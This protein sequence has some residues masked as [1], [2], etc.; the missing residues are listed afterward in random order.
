VADFQAFPLVMN[1]LIMPLFFLSGALFPLNQVPSVL[2]AFATVNPLSY[3][4]DGVRGALTGVWHFNPFADVG[5]LVVMT[6]LLLI[7]GTRLFSRIEA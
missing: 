7:M 1:F 5:V 3:G 6:A 4:V 2:E